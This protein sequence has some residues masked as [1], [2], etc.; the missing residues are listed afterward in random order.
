MK[1][2]EKDQQFSMFSRIKVVCRPEDFFFRLMQLLDL[3]V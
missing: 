1:M 3:V 2:V